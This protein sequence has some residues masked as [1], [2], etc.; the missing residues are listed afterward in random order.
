MTQSILYNGLVV[1]APAL[2]MNQVAGL[3]INVA[4]IVVGCV[5]I[6][7]TSIGGMKAVIWT[8]VYQ[9]IWMLSGFMAVIIAASID[10][11]GFGNV[12]DIV[13]K[14]GR[15]PQQYEFDPR[16]RH[17]FWTVLIGNCVGAEI[18]SFCCQQYKVQRYL[19]CKSLSEAQKSIFI[20]IPVTASISVMALLA[21]WCAHAYFENCDP[22]QAGWVTDRDQ[23]LPYLSLYLFAEAAPGVAGIYMSAVFGA[24]LSTTSSSINSCSVVLIEDVLKPFVKIKKSIIPVLSKIIMLIVGAAILGFAYLSK[25]FDGITQACQS[26]NGMVGGP[27]IGFYTIGIFMPFISEM[28]ALAGLISGLGVS[29]WVFVGQNQFPAG[30]EWSR[31]MEQTIESCNMEPSGRNSFLTGN[32]TEFISDFAQ[33]ADNSDSTGLMGLYHMSYWLV[34]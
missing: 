26:I 1:Y 6:F 10:F 33:F 16:Y 28:P 2:A 17:T 30:P 22:I 23:I 4:I 31:P 12:F 25:N 14:N 8:D 24:S 32:Q 3:D 19:T 15:L 21:G 11:E 27:T 20:S 29:I 7:Y 13:V 9:S 34:S 5:C 18:A